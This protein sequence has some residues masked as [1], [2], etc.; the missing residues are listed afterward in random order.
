VTETHLLWKSSRSLPNVPS[1][2][3][4]LDVLYTLKGGGIFASF[5]I[6]TGEVLKQARLQGA[7][8]DYY[9]SPVAADGKIYAVSEEGKASVI[10][11]GREW[12]VLQVNDLRDGCKGTPAIADGKLYIRTYGTLY[13][14]SK[15]H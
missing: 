12:R 13:C 11:A 3:V 6:G 5:D 4:Y 9:A 10:E 7:P 14:L 1:P 15:Q 2:L 8:G